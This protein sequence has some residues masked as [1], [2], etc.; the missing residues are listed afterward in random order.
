MSIC[1]FPP[2]FPSASDHQENN[3]HPWAFHL[4]IP[5]LWGHRS[6]Q[7][8]VKA[9]PWSPSAAPHPLPSPLLGGITGVGL[10]HWDPQCPLKKKL[11]GYKQHLSLSFP[12]CQPCWKLSGLQGLGEKFHVLKANRKSA[13][14]ISIFSLP[15]AQGLGN[16]PFGIL[17]TFLQI[18]VR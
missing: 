17:K 10:P 5:P 11:L 6:A 9:G 13:F 1:A 18:L 14:S 7:T 8:P 12:K 16:A 15:A 3:T 2:E 4:H